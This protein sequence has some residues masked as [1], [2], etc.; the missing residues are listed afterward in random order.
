MSE[1]ERHICTGDDNG[2]DCLNDLN[3][4]ERDALQEAG[5]IGAASAATALSELLGERVMIDVT[6]ANIVEVDQLPA[7][8][9]NVTDLMVAVYM[10]F[11]EMKYGS[12]MMTF[13]EEAAME[14]CD[15]FSRSEPGTTGRLGQSELEIIAEVGN[16]CICSYL[17]VLSKMMRITLLPQPPQVAHDMIGSILENVAVELDSVR[18]FI[19][20]IETNLLH[21]TTI[22]KGQFI[23]IPD[24]SS[25]GAILRAFRVK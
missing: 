20:L 18:D 9:G 24:C 15:K 4:I 11:D 21:G 10:G 1:K 3:E 22:T 12:M 7:A 19:V 13:P 25:K 8:L 23:F 14:L 6:R 16:I 2:H 5:N 17:N